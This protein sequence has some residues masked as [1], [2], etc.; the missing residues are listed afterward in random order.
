MFL[1]KERLQNF[2]LLMRW[3]RP[4]GTLLLLWPALI[5]LLLASDEMPSTAL[6]IIF[7]VGTFIMRSAGC[8]INDFAD[9]KFDGYVVR[10]KDRPIVSGKVSSTH[11]LMLFALLLVI[12]FMLV[13]MTNLQTIA[14]SF[15]AAFLA[16]LY[17]FTKR[18]IQFPQVI[19]GIAFG[20]AIP[21]AYSAQNH[22][23]TFDCWALFLAT[24]LWAIA[25]D[26]QYAMVDKE[27]DLKIGVKSTAI[28]F[29]KYDK[30]WIGFCHL[31]MLILL[32]IIGEHLQLNIFYYIGIIVAGILAF[33]QQ[34]LIRHREPKACFQA[35]LNNQWIGAVLFIG[36]V[37]NEFFK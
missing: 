26:T 22:A 17:P 4:I 27:D 16:L 13:C 24:V 10:T 21:M 29:G 23:L 37:T 9:K 8:V 6:W 14:L 28:L 31:L 18:Y 20:W 5:A 15:V 1:I 34:V 12:A 7:I 3:H 11:A 19:L 25:Y 2:A 32:W 35:F 33:Y 36:T 30:F